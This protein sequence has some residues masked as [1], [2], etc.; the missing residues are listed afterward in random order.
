MVG[1]T[2][3][4]GRDGSAAILVGNGGHGGYLDQSATAEP[5][6]GNCPDDG[7]RTGYV[8]DRAFS[9][10]VYLLSVLLG[11]L[12]IEPFT[13]L[14]LT[15]SGGAPPGRQLANAHVLFNLIGVCL[16]VGFIPFTADR[17]GKRLPDTE[18]KKASAAVQ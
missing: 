16:L 2:H 1:R 8:P 7:C 11:L 18:P 6:G 17:L 10:V 12:S 5:F 9:P 15:I 13:N 14:V 3:R 4:R